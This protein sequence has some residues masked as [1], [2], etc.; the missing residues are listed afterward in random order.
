MK[1]FYAL[2]IL[3]FLILNVNAQ[4]LTTDKES[5]FKSYSHFVGGSWVAKGTWSS[6]GEFHQEMVVESILNGTIFTVKTYDYIDSKQFENSQR[7][8][9][10]R[11][12]DASQEKVVFTEYD[13][14]GG[15]TKGEVKVSENTIY[16]VYNYTNKKG[17]TTQ[18]AN[19]WKRIDDNSYEMSVCEFTNDVIGKVYMTTTYRRHK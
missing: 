18:L 9:G 10:I 11:A 19:I 16:L 12:F 1:Q 2:F 14:F 6:G 3:F 5:I 7:N 17:I 4:T 13:V 8:F 15:I